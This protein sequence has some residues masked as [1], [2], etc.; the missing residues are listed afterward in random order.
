MHRIDTPNRAIDLFGVGKPGWRDGNKVGGINPTEFNAAYL[1]TIQEEL[2]AIAESV[3]LTLDPANNGQVLL[4]IQKLI[5]ARSG[6]YALDTG[7]ANAYVVALNPAIA[8]YNDGMTVSVKVINANTGASTLNAGAGVVG[9]ANDIGGA[10]AAGDLPAGGIIEATYV[11]A[12]N[13]FYVTS[14]VQSQNDTRYAAISGLATQVFLAMTAIQFDSTN[15]VATTAFVQSV[16]LHSNGVN[17]TAANYVMTAADIGR[18]YYSV[19]VNANIT[20]PPILSVP[21]G[22][23]VNILNINGSPCVVSGNANIYAVGAVATSITIGQWENLTLVSNGAT[24]FQ[25][26]GSSGLGVGQSWQNVAASRVI[27]TT[28]TNTTGKPI[29]V[30]AGILSTTVGTQYLA[31]NGINTYGATAAVSGVGFSFGIVPPGGT[32]VI[33]RDGGGTQSLM[34]WAEMR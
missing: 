31:I 22:S 3:G 30:Q 7:V 20:L 9:L 17:G 11:A 10:L 14:L 32:Y 24:W 18:C 33:T 12:A 28:Y 1:N 5:E 23:I 27:G 26:A 19:G 25:M 16:G 4:A 8:V 29:A 6:N 15:K 21:S 13:K 2:A 34:M